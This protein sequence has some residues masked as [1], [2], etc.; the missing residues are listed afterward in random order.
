MHYSIKL[1]TNDQVRS[2]IEEKL[3]HSLATVNIQSSNSAFT[4]EARNTDG[5]LIGGISASSAYGWLHIEILWVAE[6]ARC[7]GIGRELMTRAHSRGLELGCHAVWLDTSNVAA[8]DFYL[9]LN[10]IEFAQLSNSESE[11]P[12]QHR[13]WFMKCRLSPGSF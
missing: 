9:R 4:L 3:L 6:A 13:R 10:Y 12:P 2:E 8:R 1:V 5:E 7:S 11:F